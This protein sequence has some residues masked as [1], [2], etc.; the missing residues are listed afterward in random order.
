MN[1][2]IRVIK[3]FCAD[4][5]IRFSYLTKLGVFNG[6]LDEQYLKLKY[7]NVFG[8][9]LDLENPKTF[10]EKLQWLKLYNRKPEYTVMVDKYKVREYIAQMIGEEY[11][12]PLL[13]VWD[14]PDEID[15]DALPNQFVLKCNHNSG[16]GMCICKDKSKL[17][18][19][20]VKKELRKGLK[21]DY[22]LKF[23]EWPY[24][25]VP[26]KIIAEKFLKDVD[27]E[28]L[29][30]YKFFCFNG[31]PEIVYISKDN[32]VDART[33][34]FDMDFNHLNIHM[35]DP[36]A[37]VPPSKP[38]EFEK[39]KEIATILSKGIPHVR[40]DLYDILG[41]IYVGEMTFYHNGG[42][43]P[44]SPDEW[45]YKLGQMITLPTIEKETL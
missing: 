17:N 27:D 37:D 26:R 28:C 3:N 4:K 25:D 15:F 45:N 43:G 42:F 1:K 6:L 21:E 44:V 10:N 40:I 29:T 22:Y 11:L 18:I 14:D 2:Y 38:Q 7:K 34:F 9:N 23:R 32:A 24:K 8:G 39:M 13:G 35:K 36:N 19:E 33:D 20:K 41:R 31:K 5:T 30:D 16:T 12:I